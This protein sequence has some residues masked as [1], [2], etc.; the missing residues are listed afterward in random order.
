MEKSNDYYVVKLPSRFQIGDKVCLNLQVY[1]GT[2]EVSSIL[3]C[4]IVNVHFAS[5][6]VRYDLE[7]TVNKEGNS[8][9]IYNVD[10]AFVI[11]R[12]TEE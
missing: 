1:D 6:K 11:D 10:S 2:E 9:R 7:F 5:E 12:I 3:K 4:K 8:T